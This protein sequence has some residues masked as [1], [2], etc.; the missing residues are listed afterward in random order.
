MTNIDIYFDRWFAAGKL[1]AIE[2]GIEQTMKKK[3]HLT[4]DELQL[5]KES[6]AG[7]KKLRQDT[8]VHHTPPK[9]GKKI[10]PERLLQ[11]QVDASYYFSDEFQPLLDTDGPTRYVR[12]G[13]DNFEVKK[14]RRGDYSP[15]M[16][17]DLHGLTQKQAKQELGALI[18]ACKREH[19]H[20]ACVMHGHGKHVLKQQTPLWMAQ[21][22]DVLAFHQAPKEWGG[23]AALLLLIELEE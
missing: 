5:F 22:P 15:E 1:G 4:P 8:I 6:I 20:C 3:Y 19:V 21:H 14:L 18:A 23:T 11:E 9:L 2:L 12:P 7:A 17:L 16:F 13:V 10:A